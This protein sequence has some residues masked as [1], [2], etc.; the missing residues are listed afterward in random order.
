MRDRMMPEMSKR[1][2]EEYKIENCFYGEFYDMMKPEKG[3]VL[4][5]SEPSYMTNYFGLRNR[6]GIL[7]ENYVYADYKSRVIGCYYLIQS[8]LDYTSSHCSEIK[9]HS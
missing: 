6:L 4:E 7:N 5:A 2:S 1:L 3:W 8:L 9:S